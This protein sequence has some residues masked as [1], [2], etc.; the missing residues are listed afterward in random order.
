VSSSRFYLRCGVVIDAAVV[1]EVDGAVAIAAAGAGT[2]RSD[3]GAELRFCVR[4]ALAP[5]A[6]MASGKAATNLVI[7]G[8]LMVAHRGGRGRR[9]CSTFGHG[10]RRRGGSEREA[11]GRVR[12]EREGGE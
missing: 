11:S 1:G 7:G 12:G 6:P 10:R 9:A 2:R 4:H 8:G 3:R 5:G